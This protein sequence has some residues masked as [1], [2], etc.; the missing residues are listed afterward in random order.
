M[1]EAAPNGQRSTNCRGCGH[2]LTDHGNLRA[3][4]LRELK[5][6]VLIAVNITR[7]MST[8]NPENARD[9]ARLKE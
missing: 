6:R 5:Q 1:K 3:L 9:A 4:D 7:L 8:R 2:E